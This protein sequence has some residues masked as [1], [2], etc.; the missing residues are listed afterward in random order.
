MCFLV[1]AF[2]VLLNAIQSEISLFLIMILCYLA[3]ATR[4]SSQFM[5]QVFFPKAV[6]SFTQA[7]RKFSTEPKWLFATFDC[8]VI[9][10]TIQ[11]HQRLQQC[12]VLDTVF[13]HSN[14]FLTRTENVLRDALFSLLGTKNVFRNT[15]KFNIN[16]LIGTKKM[17]SLSKLQ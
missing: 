12:H 14:N 11:E 9:C 16:S 1:F 5:F 3:P 17:S 10:T 8:R 4:Y 2:S 13:R 7:L 6:F 15:K